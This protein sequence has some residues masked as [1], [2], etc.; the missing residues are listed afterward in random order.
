[1]S[2]V[3]YL[4]DGTAYVKAQYLE[5]DKKLKG[6]WYVYRKL[7]GV[8]ILRNTYGAVVSRNSKPLYNCDALQFRD[9]EYFDT[10]WNISVSAVRTESY[11]PTSQQNVYELRD[12]AV[13]TR[14]ELTTVLNPCF[15]ILQEQ[16]QEQLAK[17]DEGLV[18]RSMGRWLKVVP[19]L[20]ADVRI[21]GFKE[22]T[23]RLKGTLGSIQTAH[24][25][26]GSG[27]DDELRN[28]IWANR[29]YL[30]GKIIQVE[31]REVTEDGKLR[32]PAF[33]RFRYDKEE[34]DVHGKS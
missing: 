34:E 15:A 20:Q 3:K 17:G 32:F 8:R 11:V 31:Y 21:T 33:V 13:D 19:K 27:F 12:G 10:N 14:L 25:S 7:D 2:V 18:I 26:V 16:M 24:G 5:E 4:D 6:V 1:M 28:V 22:G 30:I 23:G 29:A 9:A